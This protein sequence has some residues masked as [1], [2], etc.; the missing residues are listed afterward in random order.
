MTQNAYYQIP[1]EENAQINF[2][3]II[4]KKKKYP[5]SFPVLRNITIA[6]L[7]IGV[8]LLLYSAT[9]TTEM[10]TINLDTYTKYSC[11]CILCI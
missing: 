9:F 11:V 10:T 3:P 2:E 5:L 1:N 7:S 4:E 8:G 6:S